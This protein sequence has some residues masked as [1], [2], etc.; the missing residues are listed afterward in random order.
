ME[1]QNSP[2]VFNEWLK[3]RRKALDLT[4]E[5][6]AK[7]AGCSVGALRKIE[8]GDRRPSKQLAGLLAKA[9]EI[10]DEDRQA[11]VRVARGELNLEWLRQTALEPGEALSDTWAPR[12][13]QRGVSPGA[14]PTPPLYRIPVQ[15]TPLIG[16]ETE[17]AAL[18][19]LF[20]DPQCRLLT[21]TG[22][23]GIG[24]TRLAIEF[25]LRKLA[26]FPG[27]VFYIPLT[28]VNSPEKIVPA[29]AGVLDFGFSGPADP[30]EQLLDYLSGSITG[31]ALFILDNL[32]HL[33][34][35]PSAQ[36]DE[37]GVIELVS[38]ILGQLPRV[39]ILGTSR[40][41]LNL[42]GEWTYELHGLSVPPTVFAGP[43]DEYDAIAL[44]VKSA[45]RTSADFEVT[46]QCQPEIIQIC[47]LV[48]G[49]PL[50]IEL[51]A[52]WVG[53]LSCQEIAQEI[54]SNMDFLTTSMRDLPER[55]RSMRA[56]FDHSWKLLS[57]EERLALCQLSVFHGGFDRHAAREI[58]GATLPLLASLSAKSLVR[59][60]ESGRYDLHEVIR[61]YALSHLKDLPR[62]DATYERH[63]EH[64]L[65]L[66]QEQ[67]KCLKSASQQESM[68]GLT[69]EIDNIRAAWAWAID[70]RKFSLLGQA[71][72]AFGWYFEIAGLYREG[73][74]QLELLGQAL[75]AMPREEHAQRVL[76]LALIHQAL[77][78]FRRGEFSLA[79]KLYEES[80]HILRPIDDQALLADAL[81]FLGTILHLSGNYAQAKS[82]LEEGLVFARE[83]HEKWFEA[84]G[85]DNLGYIASLMG[86]YQEGYLQM[87]A[88][89]AIWRAIGDPHSIALGLNFMVPTM[90]RLG[91]YEEAKIS[92]LES[93]AL[94][95]QSKN[96][97]GMG[98]AYRFLGLATLAAGE[99]KE[100]QVHLRKSLEI[101][102]EH[103]I[104]WDI[105]RTLIYL[106][107]ATLMSGDLT[108]ARINYL[109]ALRLS[110]E[111]NA[112]PLALDALS[113][114]G[115]LQAQ[116]GEAG[117]ALMLCYY[118]LDHPA[119]E[120]DT[121]SRAEGL[122]AALEA[123]LSPEQVESARAN[124][125]QKP[126]EWI[127]KETL[128][129]A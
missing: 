20:N 98:T 102:G 109:D 126:F 23:G 42:H 117:E 11:F 113:G 56:T 85:I 108:E 26:A 84:Y 41:R 127:V 97:W 13:A 120:E 87:Q 59:R 116:T 19:R 32:E 36:E 33:L 107:D 94:C 106:G 60:S 70:H 45:Q 77:L 25:A 62:S 79:R 53:V 105:A 52:A 15:V 88:A 48:E 14:R 83:S 44:F 35:R 69:D 5:E 64:Y 31:E 118:I 74:E 18:E 51:A 58:A 129:T 90:I 49:V 57:D 34:L 65:K 3:R 28:P 123:A 124:A 66:V 12:Q 75:K 99:F 8:S 82:T 103:F 76:G 71:G 96:R 7:R 30:K 112:I 80:I 67:E 119:S 121:K 17:S 46:D 95:E 37:Y 125:R 1:E 115:S 29:I 47:Q 91:R 86:S 27:G 101:F 104:G 110:I 24:K 61:Q 9:L 72:R 21:L 73:I 78:N 40:E 22:M 128:E 6:L 114:L 38:E 55:H 4:Q 2:V 63:C 39:K 100:A 81:I 92:M 10:S 50:A 93:I 43:L 111:A 54:Q 16:R 68:R 122:R 89:V